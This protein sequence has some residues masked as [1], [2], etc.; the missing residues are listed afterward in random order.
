MK[1]I[2]HSLQKPIR[3]GFVPLVDCAPIAVAYELG[4]FE[5]YD[6]RVELMR[7]PG[8]ATIRDKMAYGELEA[9]HAPAG[10]AFALSWGLGVLRK[11]CLTG[12]LLNSN[13]DAVT[14]SS[15]LH[16]EGVVDP[17]SLADYIKRSGREKPVTFGIP[18]LFSSH[19]FLLLQWLKPAG[20][21]P[22]IDFQIMV[23][24]PSLMASSLVAS[25]VDGYCVG[26]PF[27]SI[28]ARKGQGAIL[29]ESADISPL[30][31][32]KALIV[33]GEYES[34]Y[35]EHH[36]RLIAALAEASDFCESTSGR[37]EAASILASSRYLGMDEDLIR[38]SLLPAQSSNP[39]FLSAESFHIFCDPGVNRPSSEK[40]NWLVSHMRNAG[41]LA[42]LNGR[43][44][45]PLGTIFREDIYEDATSLVLA[46]G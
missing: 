4:I 9:A 45:T 12:F 3:I 10:M 24:P 26:E 19:H 28:A 23:L 30:H 13:G 33:S 27:N 44:P 14:V 8:W 37:K 41:L 18:H 43:G 16:E 42:S 39:G 11:P 6:L 46:K 35:P 20:L 31:P 38:T 29:A 1:S 32:E 7:E 17:S 40:A 22:G 25:H 15:G 34:H 2:I 21:R 36:R 5:K